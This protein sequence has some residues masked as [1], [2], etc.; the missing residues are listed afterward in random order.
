MPAMAARTLGSI[1]TVTEKRAPARRAAE[2]AGAPWNAESIRAASVPVHLAQLQHVSPAE[3]PQER[4]QRGRGPDP[5]EQ[6]WDRS[7]AQ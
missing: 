2:T 3:R 7:V 5:A 1:R 6:H 4:P